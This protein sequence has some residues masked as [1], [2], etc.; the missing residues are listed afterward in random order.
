MLFAVSSERVYIRSSPPKINPKKRT[1]S[2]TISDI[3]C[4]PFASPS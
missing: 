1:Y 4:Y 2:I 3:F